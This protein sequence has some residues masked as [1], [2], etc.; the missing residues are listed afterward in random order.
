[1]TAM[2]ITP[3]ALR[4]IQQIRNRRGLVKEAGVR[5]ELDA[6]NICLKWD[7]AG[8]QEE[9][10]VVMK[11]G[12]PIFIDAQAYLRMADY[13]LDFERGGDHPGFLLRPR[14]PLDSK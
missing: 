10:L 9:D 5:L 13:E 4:R 12:L 14:P 3:K 2:D 8:P 6:D 7:Y 1:M 11:Q